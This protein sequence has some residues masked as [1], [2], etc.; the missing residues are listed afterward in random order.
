MEFNQKKKISF[1]IFI[2]TFWVVVILGS[3]Y[4]FWTQNF[5]QNEENVSNTT[6]LKTEFEELSKGILL[7]KGY[8][9]SDEEGL[10]L[11]SYRF[12][13]TNKC[14]DIVG[15]QVNLELSLIHI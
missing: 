1:S 10:S 3:S 7:E 14:N 12:S 2:I 5:V 8:P 9:I 4:A 6:C 11:D 13:I 15:Y